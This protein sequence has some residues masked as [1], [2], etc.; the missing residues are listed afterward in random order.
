MI[1]KNIAETLDPVIF[2]RNNLNFIP[3]PWQA[4]VLRSSEKRIILCCCRQSGKSTV[5]AILALHKALSFKDNLI[6]IV[7]PSQRQSSEL[8]KKVSNFIYLLPE[9]PE[10]LEDNK[11]SVTFINGSRIVSLPSQEATLRGFSAPSMVILDEAARVSD[12]LYAAIRPMLA[13]S[14]GQMILLST[15][16][17]RRGFFS[18]TWNGKNNDWYK[19]M[20]TAAECDRISAEFLDQELIAIGEWFFDQE[21]NCKFK[22]AL[23]SYFPEELIQQAFDNELEA[24][25]A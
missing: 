9:Q 11:L 17:G 23:D 1:N 24:W 6:L 7:S 25:L 2:A 14:Q 5:S 3:D 12:Q 19:V 20:I 4:N 13:V 15:P 8:F 18:D 21:Y 16:F 10:K 22:E